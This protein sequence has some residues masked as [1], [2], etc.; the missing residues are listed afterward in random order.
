MNGAGTVGF[1]RRHAPVGKFTAYEKTKKLDLA[2]LVGLKAPDP[3]GVAI[4]WASHLMWVALISSIEQPRR[5]L[6]T[7]IANGL[8]YFGSDKSLFVFRKKTPLTRKT[9]AFVL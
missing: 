1:L 2:R 7:A 3:W 8:F 5:A 4:L 6:L 9:I